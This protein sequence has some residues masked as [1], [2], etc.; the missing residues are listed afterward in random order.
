VF[1]VKKSRVFWVGFTISGLASAVFL[2]TIW[3]YLTTSRAPF[4]YRNMIYPVGPIVDCIIFLLIGVYI[5]RGDKPTVF[6]IGL[7]ILGLASA[8][9]FST[10]WY[11]IGWAVAV[12]GNPTYF[13]NWSYELPFAI[14]SVVSML[15]G[16]YL[17]KV[18]TEQEH[19]ERT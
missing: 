19:E 5:M 10:F 6:W 11:S 16:L 17:M 1:E 9:L 15:I 3:I 7:F 18:G 4:N 14:G 12:T 8:V 13:W 2:Q